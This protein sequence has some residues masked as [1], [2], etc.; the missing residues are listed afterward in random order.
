MIEVGIYGGTFAPIHNG[1]VYAANAFY[2]VLRLDTLLV[3]PTF[4]PPHKR[5]AA[6]DDPEERL[7]MTQL[8]F[9]DNPRHI[10]VSDYEIRQGGTSYTHKTLAHFSSPD[11]RLTFLCG[12]DMF[13]TLD[14][15]KHPERIFALARIA[16]VRREAIDAETEERIADLTAQYR[17]RYGGEV[18]HLDTPVVEIS[19]TAIRTLCEQGGDISAWV[20]APVCDYIAAHRLYGNSAAGGLS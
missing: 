10:I 20:P 14:T 9:R 12:T 8:A 1:H 17:L 7:A 19:S 3:I 5:A 18:I 6:G 4:L 11:I 16:H 2:D 13:L 15:W